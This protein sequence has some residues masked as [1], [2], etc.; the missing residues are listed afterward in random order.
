MQVTM[1]TNVLQQ[2]KFQPC[3]H[4]DVAHMYDITIVQNP[5]RSGQEQHKTGIV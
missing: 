1:H 3:F 4:L 2:D 5:W